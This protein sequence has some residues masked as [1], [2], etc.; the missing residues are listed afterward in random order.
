MR[1]V[2]SSAVTEF[3]FEHERVSIPRGTAFT[4]RFEGA[5]QHDV[6]LVDGPV[7]FS[8]PWTLGGTFARRFTKPGTYSL[9]CSL[10]PTRMSQQIVVR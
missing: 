7:G 10:H 5:L 3:R 2:S 8:S 1:D 4:W 6:T 9:V